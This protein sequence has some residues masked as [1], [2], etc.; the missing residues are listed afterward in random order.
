MNLKHFPVTVII[1]FHA[2]NVRELA[3]RQSFILL[4]CPWH[5]ILFKCLLI[6]FHKMFQAI[7]VLCLPLPA[8]SHVSQRTLVPLRGKLYWHIETWA[9][10][11]FPAASEILPEQQHTWVGAHWQV[12]VSPMC[13]MP[14]KA[15]V[16]FSASVC[17]SPNC[18]SLCPCDCIERC[19]GN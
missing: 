10:S 14:C 6:F 9:L 11:V 7:P 19:L 1:Y 8:T 2:K 4:Q 12:A 13:I 5:T 17:D 15:R 18:H 16:Y 3:S